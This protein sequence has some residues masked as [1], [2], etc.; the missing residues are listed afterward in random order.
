MENLR[1]TL[2]WRAQYCKSLDPSTQPVERARFDLLGEQLCPKGAHTVCNILYTELRETVR[3][4]EERQP[5]LER[6]RCLAMHSARLGQLCA[7]LEQHG[8][9]A[10]E[11]LRSGLAV[12]LASPSERRVL[13]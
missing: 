11:E 6:N 1:Q 8:I 9:D 5:L 7:E 2:D 3:T 12:G 4:L 13:L 10:L